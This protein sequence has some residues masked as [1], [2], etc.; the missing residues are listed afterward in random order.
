MNNGTKTEL[1]NTNTSTYAKN[2][3]FQVKI[4]DAVE[5]IGQ[6]EVDIKKYLLGIY[7]GENEFNYAN[8]KYIKA[9]EY[10]YE[11]GVFTITLDQIQLQSGGD[12]W[13]FIFL[14]PGIQ[15]DIKYGL[16]TDKKAEAIAE[17]T[18][19]KSINR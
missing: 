9:Y 10:S 16:G 13:R 11:S 4:P 14:V 8:S 1:Y 15:N 19:V 6:D 3:Q 7:E 12:E 17:V 18:N 5:R 2:V